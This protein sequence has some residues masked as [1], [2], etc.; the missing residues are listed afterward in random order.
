M[1]SNHSRYLNTGNIAYEK[2]FS[3]GFNV[4]REEEVI[5]VGRQDEKYG[6][7]PIL[8]LNRN[9]YKTETVS[10]ED[11]I[12]KVN[13]LVRRFEGRSIGPLSGSVN[14]IK[15]VL[16]KEADTENLLFS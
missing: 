7:V 1:A 11:I 14:S 10:R 2:V 4:L 16:A 12:S 9:F 8:G 15:T 5:Y 6:Q 13:A 3:P